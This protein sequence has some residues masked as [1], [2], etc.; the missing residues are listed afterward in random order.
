MKTGSKNRGACLK[1]R[2]LCLRQSSASQAFPVT[3]TLSR[4]EAEL[5]AE[6]A[7]LWNAVWSHSVLGPVVGTRCLGFC[8]HHIVP[9]ALLL[10][11]CRDNNSS[12]V[13]SPQIS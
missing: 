1:N 6:A 8:C 11:F 12:Q 2:G 7:K 3:V 9:S 13:S 10:G 4:E 5:T